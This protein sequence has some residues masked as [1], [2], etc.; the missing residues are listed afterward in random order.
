MLRVARAWEREF[1]SFRQLV[2][3]P[4]QETACLSARNMFA[5]CLSLLDRRGDPYSFPPHTTATN[6]RILFE[7]VESDDRCVWISIGLTLCYV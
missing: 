3:R 7:R 2:S 4:E 6:P 5:S 1:F